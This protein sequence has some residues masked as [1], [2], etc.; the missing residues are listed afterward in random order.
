MR[1]TRTPTATPTRSPTVRPS[2]TPSA[3]PTQSPTGSGAPTFSPSRS[4]TAI[5]T[6]SPTGNPCDN[7]NDNTCDPQTTLCIPN[8]NLAGSLT[9]NFHCECL[10]D[11]ERVSFDACTAN[12]TL[13]PV[14][15]PT[16]APTSRAPTDTPTTAP[17]TASPTTATPTAPDGIIV[18]PPGP[19]IL[20]LVWVL[21]PLLL[22][23]ALLILAL[24]CCTKAPTTP[25][26]EEVEEE[27]IFYE[28]VPVAKIPT[29][30]L[31]PPPP[32][33]PEPIEP[34]AAHWVETRATIRENPR[35][36]GD[37][38]GEAR[39]WE[40]KPAPV[41]ATPP[42]TNVTIPSDFSETTTEPST[43]MT[44]S[45]TDLSTLNDSS[46]VPAPPLRW[47]GSQPPRRYPHA[48]PY[49]MPYGMPRHV[50]NRPYYASGPPSNAN[51]YS[52]T[53]SDSTDLASSST[54]V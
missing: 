13:A 44:D 43:Q 36:V 33:A 7:P 54:D 4:P 22:C 18:D 1:P 52:E 49:P 26:E 47:L 14:A 5:P 37:Q 20:V 38:P 40:F 2:G 51:N 10:R 42:V 31:P 30:V 45:T 19:D 46:A 35:Y 34:P 21:I 24:C 39:A 16:D 27:V 11:H 6:V 15:A 41:F 50:D 53:D 29:V 9:G 48:G 8:Y 23:I 32:P 25:P 28:P 3:H 17:S 12:P